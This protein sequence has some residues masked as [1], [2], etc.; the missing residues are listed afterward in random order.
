MAGRSPAP[1]RAVE[2]KLVAIEPQDVVAPPV[3]MPQPLA[4]AAAARPQ[5]ELQA[6]AVEPQ[7]TSRLPTSTL[8]PE[9]RP[10]EGGQPQSASASDSEASP[11]AVSAPVVSPAS[12]SKLPE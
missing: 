1:K 11:A 3:L 8:V 2:A 9:V 12:I 10:I 6:A 4:P 7:A 5:F